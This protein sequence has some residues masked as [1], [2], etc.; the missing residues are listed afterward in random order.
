MGGSLSVSRV[1]LG[2]DTWKRVWDVGCIQEGNRG[3]G[4][5]EVLRA[6]TDIFCG[7]QQPIRTALQSDPEL[8]RE[9]RAVK[10]MN[11]QWVILLRRKTWRLRN[12]ST[13]ILRSTKLKAK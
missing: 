11:A 6:V 8:K 13:G 7:H 9:K 1:S 2:T 4:G 10:F 3:G 12:L 5:V